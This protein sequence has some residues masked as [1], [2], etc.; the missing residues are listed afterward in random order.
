MNFNELKKQ[1][2]NQSTEINIKPD[3]ELKNEANTIIDHIRKVMKKDF[4]FQIT[5]FPILLIFPL[6]KGYNTDLVWWIIGCIC[7]IMIVPLIYIF[8]FYKKS[9]KLEFNSLKN[10]NW[11][12]YSYKSSI[13][14][15]SLYTYTMCLLMILFVGVIF[16]QYKTF[17]KFDNL[18]LY[19][20]YIFSTLV[21]YIVFCVWILKWW[22]NKL[23]KK[24]LLELEEILNQLEEE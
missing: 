12:Y 10:I 20:V 5:S 16:I 3:L 24:P 17:F 18:L 13:T 15:F 9:Y 14:I 7:A 8:K 23:Y 11:F 19:Y 4:F 2:D 21:I 22:I 6:I 1:W